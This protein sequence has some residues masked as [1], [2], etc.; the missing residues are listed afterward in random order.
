MERSLQLGGKT[1]SVDRGGDLIIEVDNSCSAMDTS[2]D[3]YHLIY[4]DDLPALMQ[5]LAEH[6]EPAVTKP[7]QQGNKA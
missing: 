6:T 4:K 2:R 3:C 1:F 7:L 5:F